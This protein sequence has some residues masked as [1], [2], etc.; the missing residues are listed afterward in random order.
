MTFNS[1]KILFHWDF[2]VFKISKNILE[3]TLILLTFLFTKIEFIKQSVKPRQQNK[4]QFYATEF[5][6]YVGKALNKNLKY[7]PH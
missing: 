3:S 6:N 4:D 2:E 7:Q 1:S 5:K